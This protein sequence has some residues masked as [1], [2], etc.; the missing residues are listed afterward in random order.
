MGAAH[1]TPRISPRM[2]AIQS[3]GSMSKFPLCKVHPPATFV[4]P[5]PNPMNVVVENLPN[6]LATLKVEVD[7]DRVSA[8]WEAITKDFGKY[9]RIPG[10]R[11][12]KAPTA[13]IEKKYRKEI[14]DEVE[15]KLLNDS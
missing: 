9:A 8:A 6:C 10:Y 2:A 3:F 7:P 5:F 11:P 15:K 1:W 14:R 4:A 13:I 12:G